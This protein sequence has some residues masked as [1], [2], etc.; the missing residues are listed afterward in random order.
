MCS[1]YSLIMQTTSSN[2]WKKWSLSLNAWNVVHVWFCTIA[3]QV[4]YSPI[5]WG[6][7]NF[8]KY[9]FVFGWYH[10]MMVRNCKPCLIPKAKHVPV[11]QGG[12]ESQNT[13]Y[14]PV[15]PPGTWTS[16]LWVLCLQQHNDCRDAK[17]AHIFIMWW[18]LNDVWPAHK[19]YGK[20][21]SRYMD[22]KLVPLAGAS[23]PVTMLNAFT[24]QSKNFSKYDAL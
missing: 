18:L 17:A 7:G 22:G 8:A 24:E 16:V 19:E 14:I 15:L 1:S 20:L 11:H 21:V 5:Q 3:P 13:M 9:A 2:T 4:F 12:T 6:K 10:L 23:W